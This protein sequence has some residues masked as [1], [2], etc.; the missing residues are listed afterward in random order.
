MTAPTV[1]LSTVV[2]APA[3]RAVPETQCWLASSLKA[4]VSDIPGSSTT[5]EAMITV[6]RFNGPNNEGHQRR[7]HPGQQAG[8]RF[9][10]FLGGSTFVGVL[11]EQANRHADRS[12][13]GDIQPWQLP[14]PGHARCGQPEGQHLHGLAAPAH[15]TVQPAQC[16]V[17]LRNAHA[18]V[19]HT[20][21]HV[22][23]QAELVQIDLARGQGE[24]PG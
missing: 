2:T 5:S 20:V 13:R 8:Q 24:S 15:F 11:G 19:G 10:G 16:G 4:L 22:V 14:Q 6:L 17:A 12:R 9:A 21:C 18:P 23:G 1:S 3:R 7:H